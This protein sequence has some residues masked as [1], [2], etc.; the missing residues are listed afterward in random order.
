MNPPGLQA[1]QKP[2]K[3]I[4]NIFSPT[5]P[6]QNPDHTPTLPTLLTLTSPS[7][8]SCDPVCGSTIRSSASSNEDFP[9]PVRPTTPRRSPGEVT[10]E[11]PLR[12]KG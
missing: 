4:P 9:A 2:K 1:L 5:D 12:T 6:H 7:K 11:R 8:R 10:K 3:M